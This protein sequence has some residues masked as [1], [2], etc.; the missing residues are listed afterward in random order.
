MDMRILF[1]DFPSE[2]LLRQL[3]RYKC[4]TASL[5]R[6]ESV[7]RL[8]KTGFSRFLS[9]FSAQ[10]DIIYYTKF[11]SRN[12]EDFPPQI[13]GIKCNSIL[14]LHS[15]T[16]IAHPNRAI[17]KLYNLVN[18]ARLVAHKFI[19]A[20]DA[21][22]S[23][24]S[25][26]HLMLSK[27][28][29]RTFLIPMGFDDDLFRPGEKSREEFRVLFTGSLYHKGA[30][31]AAKIAYILG[32]THSD[33]R[34]F[35]L[36]GAQ[37]TYMDSAPEYGQFL[38]ES[39][40]ASTVAL[41]HLDKRDF[42]HLLGQ[43]HLLLFPSKWEASPRVVVEALGCGCP[44]VCFDIAGPPRGLIRHS[45]IGYVA[46]PFDLGELTRGVLRFYD[47]WRNRCDAYT[48]LSEKCRQRSY[49]FSWKNLAP[50]YLDM[51]RLVADE[52]NS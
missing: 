29:F 36:N 14:G 23:L 43:M 51:F 41:G 27:M 4:E 19:G 8:G 47:L 25:S 31:M 32:R 22:H 48:E 44:V 15:P 17:Y 10:C 18:S 28:G 12:L 38:A 6:D 49:P 34:F 13:S 26:D 45:E 52:A 9:H 16:I 37:R 30:D 3:R 40:P 46:R 24:N 21:L 50:R 2:S 1:V 7:E 33:I 39:F 20:F 11:V 42:A 35:F 5:L